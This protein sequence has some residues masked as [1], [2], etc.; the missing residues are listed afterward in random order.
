MKKLALADYADY[1]LAA[2]V[3]GIAIGVPVWHW[4]F[5]MS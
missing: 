1:V 2:L 5:G 3:V 4:I